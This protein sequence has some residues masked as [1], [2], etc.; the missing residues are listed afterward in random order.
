[1][2]DTF[3][4][5][6]KGWGEN[7]TMPPVATQKLRPA[8]VPADGLIDLSA[9]QVE[10]FE[11]CA[12]KWFL[13][14]VAG[15]DAPS[16]KSAAW[17]NRIHAKLEAYLRTGQIGDYRQDDDVKIMLP[18]IK[19]LPPPGKAETELYFEIEVE[20]IGTFRGYIDVAYIDDDGVPVTTDHKTTSNLKWALSAEGLKTNIQ[21][22]IYAVY[23]LERHQVDMVRHR[24]VYYQRTP[25]RPRARKVEAKMHLAD[26]AKQWEHVLESARKMKALRDSGAEVAD[27]PYD[28]RTCDK[29]G[30]CPY[31]GTACQLEPM[32]RLRSFAVHQSMK[33]RMAAAKAAKEATP[34]PAPAPAPAV[35]PPESANPLAALKARAAPAPAPAPQPP[36]APA[37]QVEIV[38]QQPAPAPKTEPQALTWAE[39]TRGPR[40]VSIELDLTSEKDRQL[41]E[42]WMGQ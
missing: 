15:V 9:S 33:E 11:D 13:R 41:F 25:K 1:M 14:S 38:R 5:K 8:F 16:N 26:V 23:Q 6:G 29:Y 2:T 36:P 40:R 28:A 7:Y 21:S 34:A 18:G 37:P 12:R 17:G 10:T 30:G 39:G 27:V 31:K 20:G 22:V 42:M 4:G 35:N 24:W 19:H 32:D 3:T